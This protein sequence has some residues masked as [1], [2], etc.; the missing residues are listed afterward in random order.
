MHRFAEPTTLTVLLFP[1][2][3]EPNE[4]LRLGATATRPALHSSNLTNVDRALARFEATIP[5]EGDGKRHF[6]GVY[7][8]NTLAVKDALVR[9]SFLDPSWVD[10]WDATFADLYLDALERWESGEAIAMPWR[11]A[12]EAASDPDGR[13]LVK[14]LV[15]MNAHIN[16]DLPQSLI[17]MVG[18]GLFDRD[19]FR[20]RQADFERIDDILVGR[21]KEEDLELRAVSRPQDYTIVDRL[22]TPFNRLASKRFLKESRTKVWR[23]ALELE[24]ARLDGTDVYSRRL[25]QLEELCRNK[26]ADLLRPGQVLLRLGVTGFGVVLPTADD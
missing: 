7:F 23:N 20:R 2:C 19:L 24:R 3:H 6:H 17:T 22:L 25:H 5:P 21:V 26:V 10:A 11:L 1:A 16:F 13:P 18:D 8:R 4:G 9:G 14:V 15:S 12:F